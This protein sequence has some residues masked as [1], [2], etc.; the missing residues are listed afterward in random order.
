MRIEI[1]AKNYKLT[2]H[3]KDIIDQKMEKFSRYF[4]D[5]AVAKIFLKETGG[6]DKFVMEITIFF[7][8]NMV[9][10]EVA[11][12]NM[13][14]NIDVALPKIEGQIR[15]YRTKLS[16]L[17]KSA[18]DEGSMYPQAEQKKMEIIRTKT[19]ALKKIDLEEAVENMELV[20]HDFYI[21]LNNETGKV[22]VLYKR[23]AGNLGCIELD[24]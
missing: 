13:F 2:E 16:K 20:D 10:S 1:I 14:N 17:R 9:R 8:N 3:L 23:K 24:Y 22:N 21:F 11:S 15:K 12:D 5:D 18:L 19:M 7:G 6:K 4:E